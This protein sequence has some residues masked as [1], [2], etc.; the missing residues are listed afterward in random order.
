MAADDHSAPQA[1]AD[2]YS[3]PLDLFTGCHDRIHSAMARLRELADAQ[4]AG[5]PT[6]AVRRFC[7]EVLEFFDTTVKAH[8][9]EEERELW[10]L[11]KKA[12][13]DQENH[14]TFQAIGKQLKHEH[15]QLEALWGQIEP[16]LRKL[17]RGKAAA[18]DATKVRALADMYDQHAQFEDAVVIP[19][20]RYLLDP[21]EQAR[22]GMS[23]ALRRMPASLRAYI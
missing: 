21:S 7:V 5:A 16:V 8:H 9:A 11:L 6:E 2:D 13:P 3:A 18:L 1:G 4:G 20:A 10:P 19:M 23:I 14:E 12:T 17:A 15:D 22:L